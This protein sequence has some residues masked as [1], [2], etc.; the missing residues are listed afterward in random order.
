MPHPN[1][2]APRMGA[3]QERQWALLS[4][5]RQGHAFDAGALDGDVQHDHV[6]GANAFRKPYFV[7]RVHFSFGF[8]DDTMPESI[9]KR[10][11]KVEAANPDWG[12]TVWGPDASRELMRVRFPWALEKYDAFKYHIQRSDMSRYAIL[13]TFGGV[14]M[15]LDY[16]LRAPLRVITG[17]LGEQ[18]PRSSVFVNRTPNG[19]R[20][21]S[22]SNSFMI[23]RIPGEAFWEEVLR[24]IARVRGNGRG[25]SR[26]TKIMR[27]TGPEQVSS[28]AR[29]FN[30][31]ADTSEAHA[32][33]GLETSRFN[34]CSACAVG[35]SCAKGAKVMAVHENAGSWKSATGRA[36]MHFYCQRRTY[37]VVVPIMLVLLAICTTLCVLYV[38]KRK[39]PM[40]L[41]T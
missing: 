29:R 21:M 25:L 17:Y 39:P 26:Y 35:S 30:A 28:V 12:I 16:R 31:R 37:F 38:R 8:F 36:Y 2:P 6:S 7:P 40:D 1:D 33:V 34:P 19:I 4:R 11:E 32:V 3:Y 24:S 10:I 20:A 23:A 15:D 18:Y 13:H 14:Y 5:L 22:L 27:S 9:R 41:R